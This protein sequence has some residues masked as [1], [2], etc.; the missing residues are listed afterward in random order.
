MNL[1]FPRINLEFLE[2]ASAFS[3]P[4]N[5]EFCG[6]PNSL[7][8]YSRY[9]K[10]QRTAQVLEFPKPCVIPR[11]LWGISFKIPS[12]IPK[13]KFRI[14]RDCFASLAMTRILKFLKQILK[15]LR[16]NHK[17]FSTISQ[18]FSSTSSASFALIFCWQGKLSSFA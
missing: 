14:P 4:R 12:K 8:F 1:E 18:S 11:P 3:K 2:I 15:F 6:I 16:Q 9:C 17:Y 5:D 13:N 7:V 10:A